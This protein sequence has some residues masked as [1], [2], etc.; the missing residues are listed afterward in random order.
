[1]K[2]IFFIC[3]FISVSSSVF[4]QPVIDPSISGKNVGGIYHLR[5]K[6]PTGERYYYKIST[7]SQVSIK[8]AND[9]FTEGDWPNL[10]PNDK[11]MI[12]NTLFITLSVRSGRIHSATD[13]QISI[14]S[15]HNSVD[16]NGIITSYTST[17]HED[18]INPLFAKL[19][20]LAG[21]NFGAI[22]DSTG[23]SKDIY[24]FYNV[25]EEIYRQLPDSLRTDD[26]WN[27]LNNQISSALKENFSNIFLSLPEEAV[28]I[29]SSFSSS[30]KEDYAVWSTLNFPVQK[31]YKLQA[32]RFEVQGSKTYAVLAESTVLDPTERVLDEE[33]Y[34]TTLPTFTYAQKKI[35]YVDLQ[36][37]MLAYSNE[38][39]DKAYSLKIES[40]LADK[41][42]KSFA[43]VQRSKQEIVVE[44]MK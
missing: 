35:F 14:D 16:D 6:P 18:R 29:D 20:V 12:T 36:T 7:K 1:M 37:G 32:L 34:K 41:E 21:Y 13:F 22:Y 10:K 27:T 15:I 3:I 40:K 25:V 33:E 4:A 30:A 39:V 42:G 31:D 2:N 38:T 19:G 44:Q 28:D 26:E 8:N 11:A 24:A 23:S 17:R 43:T 5:L 9:L